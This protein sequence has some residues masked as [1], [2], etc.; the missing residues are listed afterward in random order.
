MPSATKPSPPLPIVDNSRQTGYP[1]AISCQ[2]EWKLTRQHT[3]NYSL[4]A[5]VSDDYIRESRLA[6]TSTSSILRS[7]A[8]STTSAT[9]ATS[10]LHRWNWHRPPP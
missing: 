7:L 10:R 6:R 5:V 4:R 9:R 3:V 8:P 1:Y 2:N